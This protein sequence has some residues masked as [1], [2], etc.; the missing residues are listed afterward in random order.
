MNLIA[1]FLLVGGTLLIG[2][3]IGLILY[4]IILYWKYI[5][6]EKIRKIN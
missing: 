2:L 6:K 5:K 3:G 4:S 1:Y